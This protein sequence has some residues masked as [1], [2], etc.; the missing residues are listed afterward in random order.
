MGG[1]YVPDYMGCEFIVYEQVP[2]MNTAGTGFRIADTDLSADGQWQDTDTTDIRAVIATTKDSTLL[3]IK[4]DVITET[5]KNPQLSYRMQTYMEMGLGAVRME[6][7]KVIVVPCD[8][9]PV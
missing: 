8:Q 7:E 6:E 1:I 9:S 5:G 2:Y 3:E 4:P